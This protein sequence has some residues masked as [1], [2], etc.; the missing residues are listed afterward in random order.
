MRVGEEIDGYTLVR[1]HEDRAEFL[2]QNRRFTVYAKP[3][4]VENDER[5]D[6]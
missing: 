1:V 2:R 4:P 5:L 6:D 3:I